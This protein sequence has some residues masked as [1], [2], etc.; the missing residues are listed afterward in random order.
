VALTPVKP[1]VAV[2]VKL[3]AVLARPVTVTVW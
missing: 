1:V 3:T 2:S